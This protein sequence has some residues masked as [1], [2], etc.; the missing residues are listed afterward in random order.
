ME[1][2]QLRNFVAVV[3]C[4]SMS[5]AAERV[6]V[7]QPA[8][9]QQIAGLEAELKTQLL[10]RSSHGVTPTVAGSALYRRARA[11]LREVEQARTETAQP[12][13]AVSGAVVLGLPSTIIAV[14]SGPLYKAVRSQYPGIRLHLIEGMSLHLSELLAHG[15]LDMAIQFLA[16]ETRAVALRPLIEEDL[17]VMGSVP[18]LGP[19]T[20]TCPLR[21]LD[22][23]PMVL[24]TNAQA[25]RTTVE[26]SFARENLELNVVADI[27]SF[28]ALLAVV[29]EKLACTILPPCALLPGGAAKGMPVR[30]LVLPE[31]RRPLSLAWS[32]V[33]STTPAADV[34]QRLIIDLVRDLVIGGRWPGARLY[35]TEA[36]ATKGK[37]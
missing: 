28:R 27:D 18:G 30:R 11:I 6:Y 24:A 35:G 22:G 14:L 21:A 26:R 7:A 4:G 1:I 12:G 10:I 3:D 29:Q 15:R 32:T 33:L 17:Y 25:L 23:V 37:R 8:L 36:P 2:R 16:S 19:K 13:A 20:A 5:K 34:V 31:I 9:S